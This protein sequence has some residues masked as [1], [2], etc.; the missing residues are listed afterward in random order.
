MGQAF[1]FDRVRA[2]GGKLVGGGDSYERLAV[3][4]LLEELMNEQAAATKAVIGQA[5]GPQAG[6]SAAAARA[7]V[8]AWA[9]QRKGP[10]GAARQTLED[11]QAA[12]GGWTL[13]KLTIVNGALRG[14]AG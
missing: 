2:A 5:D 4:R 10:A 8:N 7:A 12:P 11:A 9:S 6:A 13:A 14:L 3:R 1:G